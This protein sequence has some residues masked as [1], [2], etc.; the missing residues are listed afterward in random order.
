MSRRKDRLRRQGRVFGP[1]SDFGRGRPCVVCQAPSKPHHVRALGHGGSKEDWLPI[2]ERVGRVLEFKGIVGNVCPL[3][4]LHHNELH[5]GGPETFARKYRVSLALVAT[6][7]GREFAE[8]HP[9]P[10][11]K[12]EEI[13][14]RVA[15]SKPEL[16]FPP[17]ERER[18][19][20]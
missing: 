10:F 11:K 4:N 5:T 18:K 9:A 14:A 2:I 8:K 16:A 3:C 6:Q 17:P 12:L 20:A 19:S 7:I 1:L 15:L 13:Y